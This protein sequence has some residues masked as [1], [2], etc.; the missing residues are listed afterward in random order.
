MNL[1]L[2]S[3][4]ENND[5]DTYDSVIVAAE[6]EKTARL[7]NPDNLWEWRDPYSSWCSSPDKVH[8]KWI[9]V[10]LDGT[11]EGIILASFNAG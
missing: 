2:I 7:I 4:D 8:V 5:Y 3:Q 9:G 10:A 1:Y 6:S 11:E